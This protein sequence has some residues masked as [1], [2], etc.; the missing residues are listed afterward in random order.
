MRTEAVEVFVSQWIPDRVGAEAAPLHSPE[1]PA[2]PAGPHQYR[3]R[4][5]WFHGRTADSWLDGG[6]SG[7]AVCEVYQVRACTAYL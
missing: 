6:T 1:A 5:A 3:C 2:A 4:R 7:V